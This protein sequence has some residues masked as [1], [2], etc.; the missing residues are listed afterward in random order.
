MSDLS[1]VIRTL[2]RIKKHLLN[3]D[4]MRWAHFTSVF[5][6][7]SVYFAATFSFLSLQIKS[8]C[9]LQ[10]CGEHDSAENVRHS[11]TAG[12]FHEGCV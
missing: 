3:P 11:R 10:V 1:Q 12:E 8:V 5:L 7:E 9:S 2:P 4:N 6:L